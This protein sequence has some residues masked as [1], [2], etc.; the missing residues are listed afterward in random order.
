MYFNCLVNWAHI[1]KVIVIENEA[2]NYFVGCDYEE[3]R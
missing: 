1:Q 3:L 2:N